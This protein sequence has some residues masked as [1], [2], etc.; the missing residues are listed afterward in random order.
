MFR[1]PL[2]IHNRPYGDESLVALVVPAARY[3]RSFGGEPLCDLG[4][5]PFIGKHARE[6]TDL[7]SHHIRRRRCEWSTRIKKMAGN[8]LLCR[9]HDGVKDGTG[10]GHARRVHERRTIEVSHPHADGDL[11]RI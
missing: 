6:R 4:W 11:T 8:V 5:A 3:L 1:S 10:A 2:P 7:P 9:H